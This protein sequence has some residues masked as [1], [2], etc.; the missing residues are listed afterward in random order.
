MGPVV[1]R[2]GGIPPGSTLGSVLK[3]R[4]TEQLSSQQSHS[5]GWVV[6]LPMEGWERPL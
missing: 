1:M 5:K 2:G 6:T 3:M 4:G